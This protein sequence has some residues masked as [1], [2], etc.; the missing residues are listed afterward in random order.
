MYA[1]FTSY[2]SNRN[3]SC[4]YDLTLEYKNRVVP[5]P[6]LVFEIPPIPHKILASVSASTWISTWLIQYY[7]LKQDLVY[8]R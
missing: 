4:Y 6:K 5:I 3:K 2:T 7:Y 1:N 8:A